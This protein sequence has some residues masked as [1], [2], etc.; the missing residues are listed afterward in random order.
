MHLDVSLQYIF[1]LMSFLLYSLQNDNQ[2]SMEKQTDFKA[3][4]NY[5]L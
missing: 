5:I 4:I 3:Q 2:S 1:V